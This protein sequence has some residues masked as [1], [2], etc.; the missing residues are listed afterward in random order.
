MKIIVRC[1]VVALAITGA[2]ATTSANGSSVKASVV[3]TK[4]SAHPVPTCA[5]GPGV[6]CGMGDW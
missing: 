6:T 2:I 5:P 1:F 4:T 3:A